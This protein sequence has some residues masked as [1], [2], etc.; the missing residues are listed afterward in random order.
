[1]H[2]PPPGLLLLQWTPTPEEQ[3]AEDAGGEFPVTKIL[4]ARKEGTERWLYRVGPGGRGRDLERESGAG[5]VPGG[6]AGIQSGGVVVYVLS[7]R[8]GDQEGSRTRPGLQVGCGWGR[9]EP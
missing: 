6:G 9:G 4:E 8:A 2:T 7:V 3:A 1:M 5:W